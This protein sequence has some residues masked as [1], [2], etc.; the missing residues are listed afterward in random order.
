MGYPSSFDW[1]QPIGTKPNTSIYKPMFIGWACI[2]IVVMVIRFAQ[3]KSYSILANPSEIQAHI[4]D[5]R[6]AYE[7][8]NSQNMSMDMKKQYQSIDT[9]LTAIDSKNYHSRTALLSTSRI[10]IEFDANQLLHRVHLLQQS[11][12]E[13]PEEQSEALNKLETVE[14]ELKLLCKSLRLPV[15]EY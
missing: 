12:N 9:Y 10:A 2:Q 7:S 4:R 15:K 6:D 3:Q 1:N 14:T 8:I 13:H 11:L 5:C